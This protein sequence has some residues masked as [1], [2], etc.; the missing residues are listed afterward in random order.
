MSCAPSRGNR[1]K[2]KLTKPTCG[3]KG[4]GL[5]RDHMKDVNINSVYKPSG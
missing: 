4:R 3:Q 1:N 5:R 2:P